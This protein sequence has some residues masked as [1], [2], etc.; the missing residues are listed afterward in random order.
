[1]TVALL[2]LWTSLPY[3]PVSGFD[4]VDLDDPQYVTQST[5]VT[6]G[7][8][9]DAM[10]RAVTESHADNW[11]PLTWWSLMLDWQL[12]GASPGPYHV[13]NVLWHLL[14][15]LL[16]FVLFYRLT[17][18]QGYAFWAAAV[19]GLHPVHVE[20]VAWISE[21]KDLLCGCGYLLATYSYLRYG[22]S[23]GWWNWL[24]V[25]LWLS[26]ALLAKPLAVTLPCL[27]LLLDAWPLKRVNW[28]LPRSIGLAV[29]EKLAWF[30]LV[31]VCSLLA[32]QA[33]QTAEIARNDWPLLLRLSN[34]PLNYVRYL[35][36]SFWPHDLSVQYPYNPP[37][38]VWSVVASVLLLLAV[39][40]IGLWQWRKRPAV[41]IGWLWFLGTLVPMIGLVQVGKQP[42]ADRYLYLPLLGLLLMLWPVVSAGSGVTVRVLRPV[43][44]GLT[45]SLLTIGSGNQVAVWANSQTL[46]EQAIACDPTN[47][48]ALRGL[49]QL[50]LKAGDSRTGLLLI[51]RSMEWD[52]HRWQARRLYA[53]DPD[54]MQ[55]AELQRKWSTMFTTLAAGLEAAVLP[56]A[57]GT[58]LPVD[59]QTRADVEQIVRLLRKAS[60]IDADAIEPRW[61]LARMFALRQDHAAALEQCEAILQ[62]QPD[63]AEALRLRKELL[64][65]KGQPPR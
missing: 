8:S 21:R 12:F 64:T 10:L 15:M 42:V 5:L 55:T 17:D 24:Q 46:Y 35:G 22:R 60:E 59:P 27:F 50:Y 3:W 18:S 62:R 41:L 49:G 51:G 2:I 20:S 14:N 45:L 33:Q 44:A 25:T 9:P 63:H 16:V 4:F 56:L 53:G 13:E 28:T 48:E 40:G 7:L 65:G 61:Q 30:L 32:K 29:R 54:P 19:F 38:S 43:A 57:A 23:G 39:T 31:A 58:P 26:L 1:M 47:E 11:H 52:Y 6:R 34:L 36:L 37:P